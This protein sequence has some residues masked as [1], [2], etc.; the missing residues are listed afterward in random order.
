[1]LCRPFFCA[2]QIAIAAAC[3]ACVHHEN[4][5]P[6]G[7]HDG[8]SLMVNSARGAALRASAAAAL[9]G[10]SPWAG[11]HSFGTIYNLP[12][13]FWMYAYGATAALIVSFAVV[14]YVTGVP[15]ATAGRDGDRAVAAP[16]RIGGRC[17]ALL[18]G[19]SVFALALAIVAGFVGTQN[20]NTN[21][22]MTL[23]WIV[24]TLACYYVTA[25]VGDVY[26][27][28]NPWRA[29]CGVIELAFPRA[30]RPRVAYPAG[31]AYYPALLLYGAFI[32]IE[33]FG[34]TQP[35]SL[36]VVLLTYTAI[37]LAGAVLVGKD[38]WFRYGELFGVMF[39]L[40]GKIAPIDYVRDPGAVERY[41]IRVRKPF[42]GLLDEPA[43]HG[44]LLLFVLF[45][46]SSTAFDGIHETSP[47]VG[48]F[49]KDIYP[50]LAAL[51]KQP[52]LVLV[53]F[54][55]YW[56]WA[57]LFVSPFVYLAIYLFFIR[58]AKAAAGST[59]S[60][61]ALALQFAFSL[62]PIAFVYNVTHYYTLL[63]SQGVN[64]V[65]M[66]SDPFG[67]GWNLFGTAGSIS[68]PILLDAGG[69]WHTQVSL[70]LIGHIV[71]VYLAHV[72]AL[73]S[74][75]TSQRAIVSQLPMLVLMVL[76]TTAGLWILSLPIAAGQI[77]QPATGG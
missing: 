53:S 23:F 18:R 45:T 61:R 4:I 5:R 31:L 33:L 30:F 70:I 22:N 28:A 8:K 2:P 46:L 69:V 36:A 25:L 38:A 7:H 1:V 65:R 57:M 76:F 10:A 12:V 35:R 71:G 52:Y 62:V 44:S 27:L 19:L 21:I 9:C 37:N 41:G 59:T 54:Y 17:L 40:A 50:V 11:A 29:L 55:Y 56:Q 58:L 42:V 51:L 32:W 74:F 43:E 60:V 20:P 15:A 75:S 63:V 66:V 68:T 48:V 14:A 26:G 16:A 72:E 6:G 67:L 77:V 24:F 39:R 73:R 13:P 47:W 34:R 3:V 49:W 64:I